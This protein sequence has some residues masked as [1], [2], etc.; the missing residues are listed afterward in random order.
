M[1]ILHN[2]LYSNAKKMGK[3]EEVLS[4]ERVLRIRGTCEIKQKK[5][6]KEKTGKVPRGFFFEGCDDT[7]FSERFRRLRV[8]FSSIKIYRII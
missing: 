6:G 4:N 3:G 7:S 2:Y 8:R 5:K 1:Y